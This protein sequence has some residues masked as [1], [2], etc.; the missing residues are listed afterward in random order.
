MSLTRKVKEEGGS[1]LVCVP[2]HLAYSLGIRKGSLLS[3]DLVNK[4]IVMTPVASVLPDHK[5]T[6]SQTTPVTGSYPVPGSYQ[7]E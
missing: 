4:K 2:R 7:D 5:A 6:E 3:I 1:Y